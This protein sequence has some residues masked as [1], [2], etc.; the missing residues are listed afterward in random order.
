MVARNVEHLKVVKVVFHL[1]PVHN[2][3]AHAHKNL[4][5]FVEHQ[6]QGVL[7]PRL[8]RTARRRHVDALLAQTLLEHR[9]RHRLLL[10]LQQ[11]LQLAAQLVCHR[12]QLPALLRVEPAHLLHHAGK[13]AL[14]AQQVDARLLQRRKVARLLT[15]GQRALPELP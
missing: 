13:L 11:G 14:L 9:R 15:D 2:L 5:D 3:V 12:A 7:T 10:V 1:G 8:G 6:V 4:L